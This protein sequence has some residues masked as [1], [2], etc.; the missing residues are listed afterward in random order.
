MKKLL[1][2]NAAVARGAYE[3]GVKVAS[4]YPG[5]PS[6]EI[7]EQVAKY[8]N[9]HA[10]W[11][12]NEKVAL[13]VAIG[14]SIAGARAMCCMK[15]VG[16]NVA[17]DPLF[18]F[19]YTGVNGGLVLVCA[20]D[21]GMHSSQNE[22]DSRYYAIS[23]H[24]PM[25][26]PADSQE[27]K[28]YIKEAY[29]ISEKYDT[30]V[31][32]RLTTRISHSQSVVQMQEPKEVAL[33]PY[34]KDAAKFVM[35]PANA[36][37][38]HKILEQRM[39]TIENDCNN[40]DINKIEYKDKKIGV[41]CSGNVYQYV[42]EALP[43]A[44]IL[45]LG[46]V[47]P[48]PKNLI[49]EFSQKVDELIIV[50][51]LEPVIENQIKAMGIKCK[52]KELFTLQGEYSVNMIKNALGN[53]TEETKP[54]N[55]PVRPPVM[56]AGCPHRGVFYVLKKLKLTVSGDIGCYSLGCTKPL[57]AIDAVMCMGASVGMAH[58]MEMANKNSSKNT[59]AVIGDSTFIHSGIT[60]LINAVYNKGNLTLLILDNR[61]TG[62]TGHQQH[63]ATGYTIKNEETYKLNLEQ[64]CKACGVNSINVV[65]S[66]DI[67]ELEKTVKQELQKN[68]VSVII[69]RRPCVMIE[70]SKKNYYI[71]NDKCVNCKMCLSVGC[72][73]I[74]SGEKSVVIDPSLCVGCGL[75]A[76]V[77]KFKAIEEASNGNT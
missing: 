61:T 33:K 45:K 29:D 39:I 69:A 2:G 5:T 56:C 46:M 21:P 72:P 57:N 51:E 12:P 74:S 35:V 24:I 19:S 63:P 67:K 59:V 31:M 62:M 3:A 41:I 71:I 14:A 36:R 68:E 66:L 73:A 1:I 37:Q 54:V 53:K 30:P 43:Q 58:G 25:L 60:G 75:C 44:S 10:E 48:L 42:K 64:L 52:G 65:D 22:Q 26:E 20:D 23:A 55:V 70:K 50:E 4:A 13:E 49:K 8:D 18:T 40:F 76:K 15:H 7:T 17:A 34:K 16:V 6:T 77:C 47:N 38:R 9:I 32:L 28:D 11:S 27:A